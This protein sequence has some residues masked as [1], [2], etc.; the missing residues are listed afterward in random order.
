MRWWNRRLL[1]TK[2]LK[3]PLPAMAAK[4]ALRSKTAKDPA[5]AAPVGSFRFIVSSSVRAEE[6]FHPHGFARW[7][8]QGLEG[9]FRR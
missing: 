6:G 4:V 2:A 8:R 9:P 1:P 3:A 5:G 7:E